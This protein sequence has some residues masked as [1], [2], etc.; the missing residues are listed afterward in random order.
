MKLYD[1]KYQHDSSMGVQIICIQAN[2]M[3]QAKEKV[4]SQF[5]T[6]KGFKI[7]SCVER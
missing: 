2:S 6:R 7:I 4:K 1:I 5:A 3:A